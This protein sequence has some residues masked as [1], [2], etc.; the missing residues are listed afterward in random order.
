MNKRIQS[1]ITRTLAGTL[2]GASV[3]CFTAQAQWVTWEVSAG[4]NGHRYEAVP[5]FPG[6][7]W[8]MA[9][10]LAQQAGGYLA[11]ITSSAENDFVFSLVNSPAF[12]SGFNGSGPALGGVQP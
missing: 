11:T 3:L 8:S 5:G 6:L 9:D 1:I 2:V 7:T 10:Q 12:F 4:G